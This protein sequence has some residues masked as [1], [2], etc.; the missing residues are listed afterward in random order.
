MSELSK[1]EAITLASPLPFALVT[2][3]GQDA[4]ANVIGVSWVTITSWEP[5][6]IAV[7]IAPGRYTHECIE[8]CKEFV[9][10]YPGEEL[11]QAAWQCSTTSGHKVN[12]IIDFK[13]SVIPSLKVKPP[14]IENCSAV[15][16]C[17]LAGKATTGDHTLFI[18]KV[19]AIT[20]NRKTKKHLYCVNYGKLV[21]C[22]KDG[23]ANF[24]LD[25]L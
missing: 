18:G 8:F 17:Q 13:I 15:F 19:V 2:S 6:L 4:K 16:E 7:S 14:T 9:V 20:G 5:F 21:S 25:F 23:A 3:M 1:T 12:K 22:D 10:H 24:S 11:A